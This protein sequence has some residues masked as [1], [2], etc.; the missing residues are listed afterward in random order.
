MAVSCRHLHHAGVVLTATL[1]L[2]A[3][4]VVALNARHESF[5]LL[6]RHG[7]LRV[8]CLRRSCGSDLPATSQGLIPISLTNGWLAQLLSFRSSGRS[9]LEE[10]LHYFRMLLNFFEGYKY[11]PLESFWAI[12]GRC[13]FIFTN[14]DGSNGSRFRPVCLK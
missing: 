3:D 7:D 9:R 11:Q 14:A 4:V 8:G 10:T 6:H 5:E 1:H 2:R 12:R 13:V